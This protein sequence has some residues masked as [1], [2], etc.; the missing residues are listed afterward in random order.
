M[1]LIYIYI[2]KYRNN[3]ETELSLGDRFN[4]EYDK[5]SN[6]LSIE[7]NNKNQNIYP[8]CITNINAI[9][10]RNSV[11][12]TNLIDLIG[13]KICDRQKNNA[14]YEIVYKKKNTIGFV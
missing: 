11:G 13:M 4:I 12:K 3:K 2:D 5:Y 10:G 1:E 8:S 6:N 14:E 9:V 7:R